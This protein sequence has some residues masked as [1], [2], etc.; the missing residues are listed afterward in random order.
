[1]L[2]FVGKETSYGVPSGFVYPI[3]G[4]FRAL[5]EEKGGRYVWGKGLN[6]VKL[7]HADLGKQL[8][9]IVGSFALE[10]R[11]PSKTGK[12]PLVWQSC[13]QAAELAYLRT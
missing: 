6:P 7:L 1:M 4:A 2:Y 8:A 10:N 12:S 9:D 13:H 5:L 3:V 11:N